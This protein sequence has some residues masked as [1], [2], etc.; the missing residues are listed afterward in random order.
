[1]PD[2][3]GDKKNTAGF[4]KHPENIN[5][6][7]RPKGASIKYQLKQMLLNDGEYA[8]PEKMLLRTEE[9]DDKKYYVFR[10][11]TEKALANKLLNLAM[12]SNSTALRALQVIMEQ[13]DGKPHQSIAV[14]NK[15]PAKI[16]I[17]NK[18]GSE[19]DENGLPIK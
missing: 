13:L 19:L 2:N 7:G 10:I 16:E 11:P 8:I 14:E 1:M 5:K 17:I 6:N 18:S 3:F 9:R 4:D 12:R 15:H